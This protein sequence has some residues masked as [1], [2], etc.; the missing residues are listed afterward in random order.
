MGYDVLHF[1]NFIDGRFAPADGGARLDI[2]CPGDGKLIATVPDSGP[3]DVD[4]AVAAARRAFDQGDWPSHL[5]TPDRCRLLRAIADAIREHVDE[6][7]HLEA[8]DTGKPITET[9]LIDI[10]LAA[11]A[12][13]YASGFASHLGGRQVPLAQNALDF[14]LREPIGVIGAIVPY[15]FPLLLTAFKVAPALAAG[16][17]VVLKPSEHTPITALKLAELAVAVGLPPGV[18]NVVTGL[19]PTVG[20]PLV[21]HPGVDKI[22]FTGGTATGRQVMRGAAETLKRITLE[23]GGKG[24]NIV[25]ADADLHQAVSGALLG[26][27]MNQGEVCIAGTRV[28]VQRSIL[29]E[30]TEQMVTRARKLRV[31]HPLDW[32]TQVGALINGAAVERMERYVQAGLEAGAELLC[33]GRRP[34]HMADSGGYYFEPTLFGGVS[35]DMQIA[36]EEIFGPITCIIPFDDDEEAIAL[37]NDSPYGLAGG[38]WTRDI[39]RALRT[40]RQLRLG[41]VWINQFSLLRVDAPWGGVKGSGFGRELGLE[42]LDDYTQIKSVYV[43]LEDEALYLYD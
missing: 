38:V 37:A 25:F 2:V 20:E 11:D 42:V 10:H 16:N 23:L 35:N 4:A 13:E 34:E 29:D 32:E 36:R 8:L 18:L 9:N 7:A 27:F 43:E 39:K 24:P 21:T 31:G 15:N 17:S 22:S 3:A 28:F 14:T 5:N 40:A 19:G 33:G 26:A 30:F 12:F 41:G 1:D 6:L